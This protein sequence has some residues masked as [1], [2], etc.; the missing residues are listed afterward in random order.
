M[1]SLFFTADGRF[2]LVAH[3]EGLSFIVLLGIA[4]PLKYMFDSPWMVQKVGMLHGLLFV[5]YILQVL[6]QRE[7]Y[8]WNL[9]QTG[10]ALIMSVLPMGTW[11]VVWKMMP[12]KN[13]ED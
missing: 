11:Y 10:I 9:K 7:D 2:K 8:R 1:K 12:A 3:L 4:M 5:A 13:N 6:V